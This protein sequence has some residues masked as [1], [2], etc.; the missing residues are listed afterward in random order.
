MKKSSLVLLLTVLTMGFIFSA[1]HETAIAAEKGKYGGVFKYSISKSPK[2]FGYPPTTVGADYWVANH[3]FEYLFRIRLKDAAVEPTLAT[4]VSV[5]SD[6][7]TVTCKL[8]KGVKFHDGTDFNAQAAKFN[9]DLM[10][11]SKRPVLK[12]IKSVDVV[13]DHTIRVNLSTYDAL[14]LHEMA[15]TAFMA[16]PTAIEK[17]GEKWAE[18]HA[19]GT[20]AFKLKKYERCK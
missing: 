8:R 16:S 1:V 4:D 11:N 3:A 17:N 7:K 5:S 18:T 19:V 12:T 2:S 13:D 15:Q 10:I 9:L 6:G 20:G 14:V